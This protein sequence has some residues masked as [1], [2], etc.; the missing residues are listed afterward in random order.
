[1]MMGDFTLIETGVSHIVPQLFGALVMPFIAFIS[2]LW[3][4]W[5]MS[6]AMFIALPITILLLWGCSKLQKRMA[7]RQMKSKLDAG[8]RLQEYLLGI[9]VMKAYNLVGEKFARLENSF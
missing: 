4:D 6:V 2:L 7:D 5:R 3:I 1:M 8:N 9:R